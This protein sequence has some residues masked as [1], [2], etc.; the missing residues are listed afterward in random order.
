MNYVVC[1]PDQRDVNVSLRDAHAYHSPVFKNEVRNILEQTEELKEQH[2][3]S[4]SGG[5]SKLRSHEQKSYSNKL[6]D[7]I[8]INRKESNYLHDLRVG[9]QEMEPKSGTKLSKLQLLFNSSIA[10]RK[11]TSSI[12]SADSLDD[13]DPIT[14]NYIESRIKSIHKNNEIDEE[15]ESKNSDPTLQETKDDND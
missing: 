6:E 11:F 13:F 4:T 5:Y 8:V 15:E 14:P 12:I 1:P 3:I 7:S 2:S 9:F 10:A